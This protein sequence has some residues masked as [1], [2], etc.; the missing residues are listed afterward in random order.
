[1]VLEEAVSMV[2]ICPGHHILWR[3]PSSLL[4]LLLQPD[5]AGSST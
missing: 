1:M 2:T 3:A 5:P 4:Q